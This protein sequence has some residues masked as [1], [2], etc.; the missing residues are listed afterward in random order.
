[1][2]KLYIRHFNEQEHELIFGTMEDVSLAFFRF[3]G[4]AVQRIELYENTAPPDTKPYFR[5][6]ISAYR[7]NPNEHYRMFRT[8]NIF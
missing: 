6:I 4:P 5:L 7:N 2:Y 8:I 3:L 1:M